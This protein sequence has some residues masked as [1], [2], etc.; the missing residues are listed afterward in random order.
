MTIFARRIDDD[1]PMKYGIISS[2]L[3]TIRTRISY[4]KNIDEEEKI[5][6]FSEELLSE[7]KIDEKIHLSVKVARIKIQLWIN[8][9]II[10]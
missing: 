10:L 3:E 2:L 4:A 9:D 1:F 7:I 8:P 5:L 6:K